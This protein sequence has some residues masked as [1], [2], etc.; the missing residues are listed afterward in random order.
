MNNLLLEVKNL[1]VK[2]EE[3]IILENISFK[4]KEGEILTILGQNGI[5]K[6]VLIKAL[7]G[8]LPYTGEIIWHRKPKIGYLPQG[9]NQIMTKGLPLT[10]QDFF[11]LKNSSPTVES[12][13]KFLELVGLPKDILLKKTGVLSS[14]QFQRMLVAWVLISRPEVILLDEPITGIDIGGEDTIY[15]L[16][17]QIQKKRKLTIFIVTHDLNI[18]YIHSTNVLCLSREKHTCFGHPKEILNSE[19]LKNIFGRNI[20]FYE[21]NK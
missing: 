8:L 15:S 3:N 10:V 13:I 6:S 17:E 20:K 4:V 14:G 7:L 21:H 16:L 5:G 11:M 18:V 19:M 12:I 1:T 2:L 9:L